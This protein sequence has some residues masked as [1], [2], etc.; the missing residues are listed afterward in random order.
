MPKKLLSYFTC[1]SN[2]L[3]FRVKKIKTVHKIYSVK[4]LRRE[5]LKIARVTDKHCG[6]TI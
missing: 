5:T 2:T 3:V 4:L 1:R 6:K